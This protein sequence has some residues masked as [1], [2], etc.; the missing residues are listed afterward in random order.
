LGKG[1]HQA[2]QQKTYKRQNRQW[3]IFAFVLALGMLVGS[4]GQATQPTRS[5][6]ANV[7]IIK[8][9]RGGLV[10][11]R[12]EQIA[13]IKQSGQRVEIRGRQCLSSCTM[14]LGLANLCVSPRT[15]F[16]FHGPSRYGKALKASEFEYW[17]Q[18]IAGHFPPELR[19]W[20]LETARTRI[21][22]YY[23]ISGRQLIRMGF[24]QCAS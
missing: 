11:Q 19:S 24:Q 14:Y 7:I 17:S 10:R 9:D 16:G 5:N 15:S 23:K 18:F 1:V 2:R 13:I 8:N 21:S 20:Y 3:G 4:A 22:G 12:A 6:A